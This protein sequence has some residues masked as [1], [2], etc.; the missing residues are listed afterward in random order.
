MFSYFPKKHASFLLFSISIILFLGDNYVTMR[1]MEKLR[2]IVD[3]GYDKM[4]KRRL[5]LALVVAFGLTSSLS[6]SVLAQPEE[7]EA[8]EAEAIT[9]K[10]TFSASENEGALANLKDST[11]TTVWKAGE[12]ST[13]TITSPEPIAG[14]YLSWDRDAVEWSLTAETDGGSTTLGKGG[15]NGFL[16]EYMPLKEERTS[17]TLTLHDDAT[18]TDITVLSP[19][20]LPSWV[21]TWDPMLEKAD[22]LVFSTHA[23]DELLWFGGTLPTYA[24]EYQYKVQVAYL[25]YHGAARGEYFRCHE[26]LDGL[27]TVGVTN[28][29][30][31]WREFDDYYCSSLAQAQKTYNETAMQDYVTMLLRRFRPEVVIAQAENGEYGHGVHQLAVKV[32]K[33][34]IGFSGDSSK[35]PESAQEY[36]LW[37]IKKCYLHLY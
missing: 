16:H 3:K 8:Q 20:R 36:G 27:W 2:L 4:K 10:C 23:D 12:G 9:E 34:A 1:N 22:M 31:I 37:N 15:Q 11:V 24:G 14:L 28:Y 5:F 18:L 35:F 33:D 25:I 32:M 17:V 26:L 21:Q 13:L 7:V 19:G 29:P 6:Q 30:M